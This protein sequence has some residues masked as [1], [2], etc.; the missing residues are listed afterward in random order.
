MSMHSCSIPSGFPRAQSA[1]AMDPF[2]SPRPCPSLPRKFPPS[3]SYP[4]ALPT[5]PTRSHPAAVQSTAPFVA[6]SAAPARLVA[7]ALTGRYENL[8]GSVAGTPAFP[9]TPPRVF[10]PRCIPWSCAN[11]PCSVAPRPYARAALAH[12]RDSYVAQSMGSNSSEGDARARRADAVSLPAAASTA[13]RRRAFHAVA[14]LLFAQRTAGGRARPSDGLG[15]GNGGY[16]LL[17]DAGSGA[18]SKSAV[19]A[20]AHRRAVAA[21]SAC[22]ATGGR[23]CPP[24]RSASSDASWIT[25]FDAGHGRLHHRPRRQRSSPAPSPTQPPPNRE[26][27]PRT[28]ASRPTRAPPRARRPRATRAL[29]A[30]P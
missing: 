2:P 21:P 27:S 1:H 14:M 26:A 17:G 11:S 30:I 29:Q 18:A 9:P 10:S 3:S 22:S 28:P 16:V 7:G 15:E 20:S 23:T 19:G 13:A 12:N 5:S 6:P 8:G 25:S 24:H 4:P